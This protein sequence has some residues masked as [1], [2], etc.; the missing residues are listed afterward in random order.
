MNTNTAELAALLNA[1]TQMMELEL[2]DERRAELL[3]QFSRIAAMAESLM[4]YPLDDRLEVAGVF[5]P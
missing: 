1:M 3:I 5:R 2:T 4:N